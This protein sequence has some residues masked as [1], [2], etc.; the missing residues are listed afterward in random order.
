MDKVLERRA[1]SMLHLGAPY[2]NEED[3]VFSTEDQF[4]VAYNVAVIE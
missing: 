1:E 4:K 3:S 2:S